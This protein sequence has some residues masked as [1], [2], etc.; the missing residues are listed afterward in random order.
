MKRIIY[1]SLCFLV[2]ACSKK[3]GDT[4]PLPPDAELP[5]DSDTPPDIDNSVLGI[6]NLVFPEKDQ[7]C[8]EVNLTFDWS[9]ATDAVSYQIQISTNRA[10]TGIVE[11]QI[12]TTTSLPLVMAGG[13]AYY[14]RVLSI[15][16]NSVKSAYSPNRAF[17][18]QGAATSNYV[19]FSPSL[20]SPDEG[21]EV[22]DVTVKLQW[23]ASDLDGDFL[24]YDIYFGTDENPAI[25]Q[26][27][28]TQNILDVTLEPNQ[29]YY[30]QIHVSDGTSK[31]IGK[32][33][34]FKTN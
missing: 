3:D 31:S 25:Y 30:W 4:T 34:S 23:E 18:V 8:L 17:Y 29:T 10:F 20:T 12:V 6:P 13:E 32:I 5:P 21:V 9:D 24:R 16:A 22:A 15:D 33:W 27:S 26:T 14:W 7:L 11:D 19:P 1:L 2:L 28:L